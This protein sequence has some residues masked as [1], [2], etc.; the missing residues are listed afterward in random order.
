MSDSEM[1]KKVCR[2]F[3]EDT[4]RFSTRLFSV[5]EDGTGDAA[6]LEFCKY[7]ACWK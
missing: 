5:G 4:I 2:D 7:W 6:W 1:S 3:G